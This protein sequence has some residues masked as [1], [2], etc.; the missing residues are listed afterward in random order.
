MRKSKILII[1]LLLIIPISMYGQEKKRKAVYAELLGSGGI[2]SVN[3]DFRFKPGNDGLGMRGGISY[4]P[5]ATLI[6]LE[7][8]GLIGK[9]KFAFEYGLG[10]TSAIIHDDSEGE[11]NT[12]LE[13]INNF[14][15]MPYAKAGLRITPKNKGVFFNINYYPLLNKDGIYHWFGV[16]IGYSWK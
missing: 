14:G 3:Y 6:P 2:G 12:L 9:N 11:D 16:G 5:M 1:F 13:D 4:L 8:N 15:I 7:V 10:L